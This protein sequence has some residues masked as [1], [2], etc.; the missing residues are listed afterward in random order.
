M[1]SSY[2]NM[3]IPGQNL[4]SQFSVSSLIWKKFGRESYS[5][6]V[7]ILKALKKKK[8]KE[9]KTKQTNKGLI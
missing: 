8:T 7:S 3:V 1:L 5:R 9:I 2:D 4:L 6:S